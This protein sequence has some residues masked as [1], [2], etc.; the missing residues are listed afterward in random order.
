MRVRERFQHRFVDPRHKIFCEINADERA[1]PDGIEGIND[2]LAQF[3]QVF[4]KCHGAAGF[5][6]AAGV[7]RVGNR[8]S[9]GLTPGAGH[10]RGILVNSWQRLLYRFL[11]GLRSRALRTRP[12]D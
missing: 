8:V 2:A 10:P 6:G 1:D 12:R 7:L 9:H 11:R 4:K 3:S 5:F